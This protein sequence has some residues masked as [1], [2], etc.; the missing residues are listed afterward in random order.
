MICK[1]EQSTG[2][3]GHLSSSG[4]LTTDELSKNAAMLRLICNHILD[5]IIKTDLSGTIEYASPS[6]KDLLGY[7]PEELIGKTVF[8]FA[9]PEEKERMRDEFFSRINSGL[10]GRTEFRLQH[11]DDSVVHVETIGTGLFEQDQL[12]GV[13]FVS[14]DIRKR[15]ETEEKIASLLRFQNEMLDTAAIWINTVDLEGNI[16]YWNRAAEDISGY[17]GDEVLGNAKIWEWLYPAPDYRSRIMSKGK[18]GIIAGSRFA[19]QETIILCK[20]GQERIISWHSNGLWDNE[21]KLV[22]S[23]A[24]GADVTQQKQAETAL[25]K[26]EEQLYKIFSTSPDPISIS[27]FNEGCFV[28]V[29]NAYLEI[30][31]Y[32]RHEIIGCT[33]DDLRIWVF[34]EERAWLVQ[35]VR[36]KGS[37][38]NFEANIRFKSGQI[39]TFL[40]S[41]DMIYLAGK[42]YLFTVSK[43]ITQRKQEETTLRQSEAKLAKIFNNSPD[44]ISITSIREGVFIEVNTAFLNTTGYQQEEIIGYT[45]VGLGM[46]LSPEDRDF[47]VSAAELGVPAHAVE[48]RMRMKSGEIRT[49]LLSA[50]FLLLDEDSHLLVISKDIT[51]R[52]C[53]EEALRI[54][55]EHFSKAFNASP[56]TMCICKLEDGTLLKVNNSF[57]EVLGYTE[58]EILGKSTLGLG[59]WE[60][61]ALRETARQKLLTYESVKDLEV[62]FRKKTGELRLGLLTGERLEIEGTAYML[63]ILTDITEKRQIEKE[64]SRLDRLNLVG[65]FAASIGHEMRNPMT[66]VRGFLQVLKGKEKY[67]EDID[68]FDLMIE[69]LD[70]ANSI[71]SEFLSLARDKFIKLE[72]KNL[73]SVVSNMFPLIQANAM[74]QDKNIEVKLDVI[75]NLLL[76][77]KE[78]RQLLVNLVRNGLESMKPGGYLTIK[79]SQDDQ[80]VVLSVN[81]QGHGI[82]QEILDKLGT[83][84][85][86]TKEA[87]T[88]LGMAVCYGIAGHHN[89]Y[90]EVETST[91][92][93]VFRVHFPLPD[94][95]GSLPG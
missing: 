10:S 70:R 9:H 94:Q 86:T 58:E 8:E 46:W 5:L 47:L 13:I 62:Y 71:I 88:G 75:P 2:D 35:N 56:L 32:E 73:N 3:D 68:T 50:E 48:T 52:K 91:A 26:S 72:L 7:E 18:E 20:N 24:L 40:L 36:E 14:R 89:A 42:P 69:E 54:S 1:E 66:T 4:H 67:L 78:I 28:E 53:I 95:Q 92:G 90:I 34:P 31:G 29:N 12:Y 63:S 81:D 77:E 57:C 74:A 82:P 80:G 23:L 16:V 25:R 38:H 55:E 41:A 51:E 83:P 19:N 37:L 39:H 17:T 93:S 21:G 84:F 87:G 76:D 59:I 64:F 65:Q 45:S 43:D 30:T 79:T 15:K 44:P 6:H 60:D 27:T 22:G 49:F 33:V 11:V 85:L 61:P